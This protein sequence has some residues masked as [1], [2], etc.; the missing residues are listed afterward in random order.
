[1]NRADLQKLSNM[2]IR[3]AGILLREG[4]C[5]GAYYLAGYS[6]E[7]ALKACI[8][9]SSKRFDFPDR[10]RVQKSY[11]HKLQELAVLAGLAS[12]LLLAGEAKEELAAIWDLV[13]AWSE[14]SRYTVWSK[15]EAED[16]LYAIIR[17]NGGVL[18]WIKRHW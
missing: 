12:A 18:P 1:M 17:R 3:E 6:V 15:S 11:S 14:Q 5:S 10:D 4:E 13:K 16:L 2:R 8:A 7:C 9:K